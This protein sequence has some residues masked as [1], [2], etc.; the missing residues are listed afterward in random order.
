MT[1][2]LAD[3]GQAVTAVDA[4]AGVMVPKV[5]RAYI[6]E[7]GGFA[8]PLPKRV[9]G[10]A[11]SSGLEA[12]DDVEKWEASGA[13]GLSDALVD[14][15]DE[16]T[17]KSTGRQVS[18]IRSRAL[19]GVEASL[20]EDVTPAPKKMVMPTRVRP[21]PPSSRPLSAPTSRF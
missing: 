10:R 1:E 5:M 13:S 16:F 14:L 7:A 15:V 21:R 20:G 9:E 11:P 2:E 12:G 18:R 19:G 6:V 3:D 4:D 17:S 8:D